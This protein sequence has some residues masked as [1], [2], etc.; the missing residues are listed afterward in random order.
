MS[1][2]PNSSDDRCFP[3]RLGHINSHTARGILS[4]VVTQEHINTLEMWAVEEPSF[5]SYT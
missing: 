4:L 2:A 3:V 5:V 1:S